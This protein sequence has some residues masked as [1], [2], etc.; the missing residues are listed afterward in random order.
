MAQA[1]KYQLLE[2]KADVF[3]EASGKS[4]EQALENAA[5]ALF[6][7]IADP[8]KVGSGVE[9]SVEEQA[10][11]L[12]ELAVLTLAKLLTESDVNECFFK[13]FRVV[14]FKKTLQGYSVK[15]VAEGGPMS[16]RAGRTSVKAVTHHEARVT[17]DK[18]WRI[19]ILLDI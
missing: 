6:E 12:E 5:Q 15:G 17:H 18:E 3:F 9:A 11:S 4:F 10:G 19:R 2:H 16:R 8:V 13:R 1:K 7:T 14:Q